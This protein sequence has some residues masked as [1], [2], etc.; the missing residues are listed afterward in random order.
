MIPPTLSARNNFH[1]S[2]LA[3]EGSRNY[4][5]VNEPVVDYLVEAAEAAESL[6]DLVAAS[7]ALDRVM[8]WGYYLIPVYAYDARRTVY[9]DKFGSPPQPSYRPAFPDG[10]WYE[11][12]KAERISRVQ[13]EMH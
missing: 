9:W 11:K 4:V 10:W 13:S 8:M 2:A 6:S 5:G 1:S 3:I 12:D 7:R